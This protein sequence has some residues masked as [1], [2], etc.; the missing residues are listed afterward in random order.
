MPISSI[1]D[2]DFLFVFTLGC[3]AWAF[4]LVAL[5][6]GLLSSCGHGLLTAMASLVAEHRL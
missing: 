1:K 4:L 6:G 2:S 5:G 3:A